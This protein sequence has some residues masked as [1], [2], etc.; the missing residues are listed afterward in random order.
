[1]ARSIGGDIEEAFKPEVLEA[2]EK[3]FKHGLSLVELMQL[4]ELAPATIVPVDLEKPPFSAA[5]LDEAKQYTK[6]GGK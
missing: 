3:Q 5:S 2:S 6:R 1:L 4:K